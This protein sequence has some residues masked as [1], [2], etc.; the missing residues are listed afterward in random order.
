[1]LDGK[2]H[3]QIYDLAIN[4]NWHQIAFF[5]TDIENESTISVDISADSSFGGMGLERN[6]KYHVYD[7]WNDQ[8]LGIHGGSG[9]LEQKLRPGEVRMMSVHKVIDRPVFISTNRH[10]MQGYVD[11]SNVKWNAK[12]QTLSGT[13]DVIG[14]ETFKVVIA[15]NGFMP[16]SSWSDQGKISYVAGNNEYFDLLIDNAENA[17]VG[18]S[19]R[20]E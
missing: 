13:A 14:G 4:N 8:Y 17:K 9:K 1:M 15:S 10:V 18:W 5:N 19:I 6:V 12:T 11:L 2:E 7:F 3:P 20:F 16:V